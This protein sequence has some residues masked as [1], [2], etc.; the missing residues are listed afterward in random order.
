MGAIRPWH[1]FLL[2]LCCLLPT[3]AAVTGAVWAIRRSRSG[4]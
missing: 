3:T 1:L 4:R 2:L